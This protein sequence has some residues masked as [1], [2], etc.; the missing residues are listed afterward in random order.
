[1]VFIPGLAQED[2]IKKD[3][4]PIKLSKKVMSSQGSFKSVNNKSIPLGT[5]IGVTN[6]D[7]QSNGTSDNRIINHGNSTFSAVWTQ[8][9]G[10]N[11]SAPERGTGYNYFD[12]AVW[13][14]P[15][16]S[17]ETLEG[18]QRT[19]WPSIMSNGTE[20]FVV[21]HIMVDQGLFGYEQTIGNAGS[22]WTQ[23]NIESGPGSMIFPRAANSENYYYVIAVDDNITGIEGLHFFKSDNA[24]DTWN[25]KGILPD[26]ELHYSIFDADTYSIDAKDNYVAVV[27]FGI[28]G[29][30]LLWKS[31][32][33]GETWTKSIINDFPIDQYSTE[34]G[35]IIDLDNNNQADT[36]LSSDGSG[37]V[38]ID[39]SGKVH[40]SFSIMKYYDEDALDDSYTYLPYTDGLFYWN[41]DM[42]EGENSGN[43]SSENFIDLSVSPLIQQI[44]WVP[45]LDGNG[46]I[47]FEDV[48][49]NYPFGLYSQSLTTFSNIGIDEN[50]DIYVVYSTV[51]EGLN[52]LK[53]D[54]FPNAQQFRHVWITAFDNSDGLWNV[55]VC[56]SDNDGTFA[57]C[58]FPAIA[59]NIDD[60]YLNIIYQWDNEPGLYIEGAGDCLRDN[61]IIYK[62]IEKSQ[63]L[64]NSLPKFTLNPISQYNIC[65]VTDIS[66]SVTAENANS[67][68]WQVSTDGCITYE[69]IYD[70]GSY[71]NTSTNT[72]DI[73]TDLS[74]DNNHYR[75][76]ITN[77]NGTLYSRP[78]SLIFDREP[79]QI[80]CP[81]DQIMNLSIG[82][83][84]YTVQ[85]NEFD[86]AS[87]SDNCEIISVIND[88][89]N[90]TYLQNETFPPGISNIEWTITDYAS[91]ETMCSFNV[92]VNT[93]SNIENINN[94]IL[95]IIPNPTTGKF[96][97]ESSNNIIKDVIIKD[98]AG[99]TVYKRKVD[100]KSLNVNLS[101]KTSGIYMITVSDKFSSQTFRVI[102][103]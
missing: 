100:S 42:G 40:V 56:I 82:E 2:I 84:E 71:S 31:E 67:Y 14:Y 38:I 103:K 11:S 90:M 48:G 5:P 59:N 52:Y 69:N 76:G 35:N 6:F 53:A 36:V 68:Q 29:D 34:D 4:K 9:H 57:E 77:T 33:Y 83:T 16:F 88:Y 87:F 63:F 51:M 72:L 64:T 93:Y 50:N 20:E 101:N 43:I 47:D 37:S 17:N 45:D 22:N 21:S 78:A 75:C 25:Y 32:D 46:Q 1:M 7:L 28:F 66:Y 74:L 99:K 19:G 30:I 3:I 73:S 65:P 26:F 39:N 8:Y 60:N 49:T 95:K 44:G 24:G 89:N 13:L 92:T 97:I 55:P 91:N 79:P 94:L 54:A 86:P 61:Y 62:K 85:A 81:E 98:I 15:S 27:I 58:V 102:K 12:G 10:N 18:A 23:N 70:V 96:I 80:E 41:E